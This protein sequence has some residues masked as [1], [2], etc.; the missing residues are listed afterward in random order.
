MA[1]TGDAI[2]AATAADWGLINQAVPDDELDAADR[3]PAS[4]GPPAAARCRKA[5]GKHGFYAQVDLDQPEAYDYAI[6]ADGERG[7]DRRRP[8]RHRRLPREAQAQLHPAPLTYIWCQAPRVRHAAG[9]S[10]ARMWSMARARW[11]RMVRAVT[12]RCCATSCG[13]PVRTS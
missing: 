10:A 4:P 6:E 12:L 11:L 8:G 3:R 1:L 9:S 2:D 7:H 13:E 5:L